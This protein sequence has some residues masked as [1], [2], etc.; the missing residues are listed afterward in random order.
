MLEINIGKQKLEANN[1]VGIYG[2]TGTGKSCL[3][4][5]I[6]YRLSMDFLG[7]KP[8]LLDGVMLSA[9]TED[10]KNTY[11]QAITDLANEYPVILFIDGLELLKESDISF[12][13]TLTDK[14]NKGEWK[15][16]YTSQEAA[17]DFYWDNS[18]LL[19][20]TKN[21]DRYHAEIVLPAGYG[22][23]DVTVPSF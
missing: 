12:Y 23:E 9:L 8:L 2:D 14:A 5:Q 3:M 19:Y 11:I 13:E 18:I 7:L 10:T 1:I 15:L 6:T 17:E 20:T 21:D 22:V 4:A 16:I